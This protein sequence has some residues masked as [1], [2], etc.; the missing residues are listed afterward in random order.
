MLKDKSF[1]E[2]WEEEEKAMKISLAAS[3]RGKAERYGKAPAKELVDQIEGRNPKPKKK[4]KKNER[5]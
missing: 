3:K 4:K 1:D 5:V 2:Y